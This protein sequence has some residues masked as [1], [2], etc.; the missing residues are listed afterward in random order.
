MSSRPN[1]LFIVADQHNAKVLGCAGHP[2]VRTPHLDRMALEG[3]R[4]VNA[5][6]QNPICT[7]SRTSFLSGQYCHNHGYYGLSGPH[8]GRL[9]NVFG[10]FREA[11]YTTAALGKIHCPEYWVEDD[12]DVFHETCGTSV[13]G[14]SAEYTRFLRE[15]RVE[16]LEDH[17]GLPEFGRG[18]TQSME[19]RPSP[20][21]FEESQEGWIADTAIGLMG[22]A[23][24]AGRPFFVHCSLP[25]PHQCTSPS[26]EFWDLYEDV[27]L[28]LPP[29]A[30]YDMEG[31]A[32][33][34]RRAA[35]RWRTGDW[36]LLDPPDF[37]AGRRRKLRGY[38]GAVSQV[39]AAV[40]RMLEFLRTRGLAE[41]TVVVYT[42]DHGDY[43]C[44]HGIMEKAPGICSDA[45]TRVPHIW[46]GPGRFRAGHVADEIVELVDVSQ[47]LCAAAGLD[48]MPTSDGADL[49]SLLAGEGQAVHELGVTEFAWSRSVRR[50]PWRYVHY[51][52]QMFAADH[53]DGFGELY[54]LDDDPWEMQN[55]YFE[56]DH[57][58]R[59]EELRRTLLDWLITTTRPVTVLGVNSGHRADGASGVVTRFRTT[60]GA[61]GRASPAD[62]AGGNYL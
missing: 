61:D 40:G 57:Q 58:D 50:G 43:A 12:C 48:P 45:I 22:D 10:H 27:D 54:N 19:G 7:P 35:E 11:G 1:V 13:G 4:F 9:P 28:T 18:G 2:E 31:K 55:L 47:T 34:L 29:N 8:P 3:V 37:E 60:L 25:R 20:L 14:R 44:E 62:I 49:S 41:G 15:R 24:D 21:S 59:V 36:T 51:P 33:H 38:L 16:H 17:G 6:T 5:I 46:W 30:D 32:P 26:P 56:E 52:R 39:D 42:A 53:P 23:A